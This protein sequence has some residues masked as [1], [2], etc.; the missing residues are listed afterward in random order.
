[1]NKTRHE[2]AIYSSRPSYYKGNVVIK[3]VGQRNVCDV[4]GGSVQDTG[5]ITIKVN[6]VGNCLRT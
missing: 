1:M 2:Q 6:F 5:G 3:R 4:L